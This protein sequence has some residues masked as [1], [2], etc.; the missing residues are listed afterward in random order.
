MERFSTKNMKTILSAISSHPLQ[1]RAMMTTRSQLSAAILIS[2]ATLATASGQATLWSPHVVRPVEKYDNPPALIYRLD[3]SPRMIS[4][5]GVFTSYQVN[6]D[7]N[8]NNIVGDAANECSIS[9]DPTNGNKMVIGWRQFNNVTS[10]FRQGGWGY[11]TDAGIHWTFPGVLE[12]NVF[13]SDPVTNSD[14][15]GTFFYLSLLQ[16]FCENMYRSTNGGQSWTQLQPESLAGGGDKQW[17]TIDKTGGPGHGFQYQ[18]SDGINCSGNGVQFQRSTDGG[19]TWQAPIIIPSGPT[20]GTLDVDTNGNLFIGGEV[21]TLS[22]VRSS[23]AQIGGQTPTFDRVTQNINMGGD[24]NGGGI[25]PA[26]LDGMLFLA[27]DRSG[28]PTKNN[29]YMLASVLP[30][31]RNTTDV[32]FVRSTDGGLT[33]SAPHRINDDANF[34][35]KWHW[36]ATFAVAPN[37]RLDAVWYDNRNASDDSSQLFYS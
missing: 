7:A 35:A 33:F 29:M 27:I 30:S 20:D 3:T 13:R 37:G 8:G 6:V 21:H 16:T 22:L 24:L 28:G 9:V 1:F 34:Q 14:E 31:G 23:N 36:F 10:N 19:I 4:P 11:T 32:M 25:N 12:N 15:T 5:H 18:S 26:G 2:L 17:F